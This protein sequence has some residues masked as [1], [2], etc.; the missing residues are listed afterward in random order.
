[1]PRPVRYMIVLTFFFSP[2]IV[3]IALLCCCFDDE[4]A[5]DA[6]KVV[7]DSSKAKVAAESPSKPVR[8]KID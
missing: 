1:M 3:L 5:P 8:A 4:P 2:I 6:P 7:A